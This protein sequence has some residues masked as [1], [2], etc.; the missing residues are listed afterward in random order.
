M[1]ETLNMKEGYDFFYS[2]FIFPESKWLS[3]SPANSHLTASLNPI[4]FISTETWN[5]HSKASARTFTHSVNMSWS[6]TP[7][8][9]NLG[10]LPWWGPHIETMTSD[11]DSIHSRVVS[12]SGLQLHCDGGL[13]VLVVD[14]WKPQLVWPLV[15]GHSLHHLEVRGREVC[16]V[17]QAGQHGEDA[18]GVQ[19]G[20][21]VRPEYNQ[22]VRERLGQLLPQTENVLEVREARWELEVR[23]DWHLND[24]ALMINGENV[25]FRYWLLENSTGCNEDIWVSCLHWNGT[26]STCTTLHCWYRWCVEHFN[27]YL[28]PVIQ[29]SR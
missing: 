29:P 23:V 5:I 3:Y 16:G 18:V 24:S 28:K 14:N 9:G 17:K 11:E 6:Y 26:T 21:R 19:D 20:V 15:T 27:N 13:A 22:A 4:F 12:D 10:C 7:F 1:L 2:L 8:R 25:V